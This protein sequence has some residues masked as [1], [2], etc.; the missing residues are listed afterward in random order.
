MIWQKCKKLLAL[1]SP[2][3]QLDDFIK[4]NVVC[5]LCHNA[6][7]R[8]WIGKYTGFYHVCHGHPVGEFEGMF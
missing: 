4:F 3:H 7:I 6:F 1:C 2:V 8:K 5:P